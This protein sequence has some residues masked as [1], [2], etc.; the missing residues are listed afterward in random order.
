MDCKVCES[1]YRFEI[2]QAI[3]RISG[4]LTVADIAKEFD[5]P[6]D[7]IRRHAIMHTPLG[8]DT[9]GPE[10]DT[11]A[12]R[13]KTKEAD[14]LAEVASEYLIT[15]KGVSR[16]IN[17]YLKDDSPSGL[18]TFE[19]LLTK[20]IVDL[21]LGMGAEVRSTVKVLAEVNQIMN[22]P[23][24]DNI[25]GLSALASAISNSRSTPGTPGSGGGD[26]VNSSGSGGIGGSL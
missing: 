22:G 4:T 18:G 6:E 1:Q 7:D 20:P 15:L 2:E 26:S 21:Y 13:I 10:M 17:S 25:S 5:V 23:K 9:E 24:E 16:R 11:I 19:K 8:V 12:S 14:M 3:M